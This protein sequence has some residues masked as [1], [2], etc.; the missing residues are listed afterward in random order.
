MRR[1]LCAAWERAVDATFLLGA[2]L[3]RGVRQGR[4]GP[5]C[6][7]CARWVDIGAGSSDPVHLPAQVL[8]A[9]CA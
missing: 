4:L 1:R 3:Q 7:E 5:R 9:H 8:W 2:Q 6:P